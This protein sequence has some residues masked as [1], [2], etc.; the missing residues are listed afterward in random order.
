M[1]QERRRHPRVQVNLSAEAETTGGERFDGYVNDLSV[2]GA[3]IAT[4]ASPAVGTKLSLTVHMP[5]GKPL[6]VDGTIRWI[7]PD[8][9]GVQF[10]LMGVRETYAVGELLAGL[11]PIPDSR[12]PPANG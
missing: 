7:K 10:G 11:E 2:G 5:D 3:F 4:E 6:V 9:V 8:G 1:P 12:R